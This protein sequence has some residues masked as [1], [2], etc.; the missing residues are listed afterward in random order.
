MKQFPL[1]LIRNYTKMSKNKVEKRDFLK[2]C[3]NISQDYFKNIYKIIQEFLKAQ[4]K[5]MRIQ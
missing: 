4:H 3:R 1:L 5:E 2:V